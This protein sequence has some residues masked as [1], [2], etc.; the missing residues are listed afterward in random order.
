MSG[1]DTIKE[2]KINP[3][4]ANIPVI[5]LS[6]KNTH[7]EEVIGFS[8]GA[9]DYII[10]PFSQPILLK[11]VDLHLLLQSQYN[12]IREYSKNLPELIN[13]RTNDTSDLQ[14]AVIM[15]AAEVIEF[16]D[17]ETGKH[18]ERVQK[19]LEL[20][21]N[22]MMTMEPYMPEVTTWDNEA[23]LRSALLYDVGKIKIRDDV[24]LKPAQLTDDEFIKMKSHSLYGKMLL[25]RLENKVPSQTFLKYAITL[26][27]RHHEK[28]NGTGYPDGLKGGEIPLQARMITIADVYDALISDRPYKRAFSHE[29]AIRIINEGRGTQ[30][31]PDLTDVFI[32][33]S[34]KI[35]GISEA[36]INAQ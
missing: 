7:E 35:R 11:R 33:L 23:F 30:F 2:L 28:W 5:F 36:D 1:Y 20:M 32:D 6:S 21:L 10:K 26:A 25:E 34:E 3:E 4:T 12:M 22:K 8:L 24:L 17:S 16:R 27:Y 15:W 18:V 29:K 9:V 14:N 19:Y 31:D 13:G